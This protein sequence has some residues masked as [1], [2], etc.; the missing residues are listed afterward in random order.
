MR[1]LVGA[2]CSGTYLHSYCVKPDISTMS[3]L[4]AFESLNSPQVLGTLYRYNIIYF[5]IIYIVFTY[6]YEIYTEGL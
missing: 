1:E 4:K 5:S 2:R 3:R 6:F